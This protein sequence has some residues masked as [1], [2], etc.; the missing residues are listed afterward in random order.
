[1][2]QSAVNGAQVGYKKEFGITNVWIEGLVN[3]A[4]YLCCSAIGCWTA[5][6]LNNLFGRK[7]TIFIS[8][9]FAIASSIWQMCTHSTWALFAARFI[10]GLAIGAKSSTTPAYSAECAPA[11]IRGAI[12]TQWQMWTA[13]GIMLG[14]IVDV[15]FMNVHTPVWGEYSGWRI[16]LGS[17]A[18]P[19]VHHRSCVC[20][21]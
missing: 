16:I 18:A 4:P 20:S 8:C 12:G 10:M 11:N 14:L 19:Y 21:C 17:T 6:F 7:G 9:L 15:A 2:D 3:G 1:M 5:P 13:F